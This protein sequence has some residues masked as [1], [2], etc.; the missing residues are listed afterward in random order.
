[1]VHIIN[2]DI[3]CRALTD[4]TYDSV[5]VSGYSL[6]NQLLDDKKYGFLEPT[7][8]KLYYILLNY[9]KEIKDKRARRAVSMALF[10]WRIRVPIKFRRVRKV[11]DADITVEFRSEAED[12]LLNPNTLAYMYYPLG[13][14]NDGKC[15]VNTKFYWTNDGKAVDMHKIDPLHYP[16]E[17][18]SNPRGKTYDLDQVLR[19]EFGHGVFGLPHS[20][21]DDVV[22]TGNE[23]RMHEHLQDEDVIRAQAKAGVNNSMTHRLLSI[24]GWYRL[25]SDS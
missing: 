11:E 8:G 14:K 22:M 4:G 5:K 10:G 2:G 16:V 17:S 25:R 20:Q 19:H 13:G 21:H 24:L 6:S 1:M 18:D 9:D 3:I 12:A 23:S 7:N 15:V